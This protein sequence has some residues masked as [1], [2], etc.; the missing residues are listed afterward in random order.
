MIDGRERPRTV[1]FLG[2]RGIPD[3]Q[4]GVER[5]VEALAPRLVSHGWSAEV[6]ARSPYLGADAPRVW[7]GVRITPLWT[8]RNRFL[9]ALLHTAFGVILAAVRRPDILHIHAIGPALLTPLARLLGLRVVVTHHGF[10][11]E[12]QKWGAFARLM[13]RLG[14]RIGLLSSHAVIAVSETIVQRFEHLGRKRIVHIPNGIAITP[15]REGASR[16]PALDLVPR[17]YILSVA[18]IVEEKRQLDLIEAFRRLGDPS[19]KLVIV[20]SAEF[21]GR[22]MRQVEAAA[23]EVPGVVMTGFQTGE[24]LSQLFAHAALFC[25]PS[26]HEGMPIALLEALGYGLPVLASDIP[27]NLA[28][29]LE[30]RNYFPCGDIDAL[31]EGLRRKLDAPPSPEVI[32]R[33]AG[34]AVQTYGWGSVTERTAALYDAVLSEGRSRVSAPQHQWHR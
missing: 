26:S 10:D 34:L 14:E 33:R 6:V 30:Q 11:Y 17:G 32:R 31:C 7:N 21:G 18:R 15:P 8:L 1:L 13:L 23:A 5:H 27:A 19:L 2:L 25:L 28:I 4:G 22:Y 9:E 12:R 29:G 24:T 20:G 16:L 3:L